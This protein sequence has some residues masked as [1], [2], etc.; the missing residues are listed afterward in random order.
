MEPNHSILPESWDYLVMQVEYFIGECRAESHINLTLQKGT[1]IKC[2]RFLRPQQI[3]INNVSE[4]RIEI[5]DISE[6]GWEGLHLWVTGYADAD[7]GIEFYA[8]AVV[9]NNVA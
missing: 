4:A 2:L 5:V 9:E 7:V 8:D 3:R 6:R 1:S